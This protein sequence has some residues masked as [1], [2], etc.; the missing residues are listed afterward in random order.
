[1]FACVVYT[2]PAPCYPGEYRCWPDQCLSACVVCD[3]F[4]DCE[5]DKDE[6]PQFCGNYAC[7]YSPWIFFSFL[8]PHMVTI[9]IYLGTPTG[10]GLVWDTHSYPMERLKSAFRQFVP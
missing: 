10:T 9:S 2:A 6:D 4:P 5:N 1:M 7:K 3:G 8:P